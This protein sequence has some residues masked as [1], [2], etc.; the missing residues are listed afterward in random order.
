MAD[1]F[2]L[3]NK[4]GFSFKLSNLILFSINFLVTIFSPLDSIGGLLAY[5]WPHQSL[6]DGAT[7]R[8]V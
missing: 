3:P 8:L 1:K 6:T 4:T 2:M 7:C 5:V